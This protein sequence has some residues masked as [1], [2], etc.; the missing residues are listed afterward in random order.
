MF[1]K[2]FAKQEIFQMHPQDAFEKWRIQAWQIINL[3]VF[4]SD[5]TRFNHNHSLNILHDA[6]RLHA[7]RLQAGKHELWWFAQLFPNYKQ[8]YLSLLVYFCCREN[9]CLMTFFCTLIQI[10]FMSR[11]CSHSIVALNLKTNLV[12]I[13]LLYTENYCAERVFLLTCVAWFPWWC[14]YSRNFQIEA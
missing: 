1:R 14:S 6:H 7:L 5:M 2:V 3:G 10:S 11:P 13:N 4:L 12:C 8:L 9:S